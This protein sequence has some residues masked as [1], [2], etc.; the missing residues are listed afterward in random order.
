MIKNSNKDVISSASGADAPANFG[1]G[2]TNK[3]P[4]VVVVT[5]QNVDANPVLMAYSDQSWAFADV[6]HHCNFG[7]YDGGK[8]EGD[9]GRLFLLA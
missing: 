4:W 1:V 2:V 5:A 3:L 7:A 9:C 8:E 6:A